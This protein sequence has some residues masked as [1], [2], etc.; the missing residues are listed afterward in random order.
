MLLPM[1]YIAISVA[2]L[3]NGIWEFCTFRAINWDYVIITVSFVIM[4]I[5]TANGKR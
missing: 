5:V 4:A 1:F 2:Y 3:L